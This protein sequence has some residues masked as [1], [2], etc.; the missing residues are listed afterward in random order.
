[1]EPREALAVIRL[2]A[3]GVDPFTGETYPPDSPYQ[4]VST[5]RALYTAAQCI[6]AIVKRDHQ[7]GGRY[8]RAGQTWTQDES[9][10]LIARF[11][12]GASVEDLAKEHRRSPWA[13]R[14]QLLKLGKV[15]ADGTDT[16]RPVE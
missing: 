11:D 3:E 1:M 13:I 8:E 9:S 15:V 7:K 6:E 14:A 4:N 10:R 16:K 2:L 5:V 12:Q